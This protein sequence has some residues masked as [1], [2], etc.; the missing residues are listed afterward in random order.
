MKMKENGKMKKFGLS[1]V[2]GLAAAF[3]LGVSAYPAVAS[4]AEVSDGA[5]KVAVVGTSAGLEGVD[6]SAYKVAIAVNEDSTID[7][8]EKITVAFSEDGLTKFYRSIPQPTEKIS[9]VS[10]VCQ[11]NEAFT[12]EVVA[13]EG[14]TTIDCYGGVEKGNAWTYELNYTVAID[15]AALGD[16]LVFNIV[17]EEWTETLENVEAEITMP[18]SIVYYDAY[19]GEGEDKSNVDASLSDDGKTIIVSSNKN[20]AV[21]VADAITVKILL[22]ND[23]LIQDFDNTMA[24]AEKW[25]WPPLL[26]WILGILAA[27]LCVVLWIAV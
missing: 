25:I 15:A 16:E 20:E 21:A 5:D 14:V 19:S 23:A 24:E 2:T 13:S 1:L 10:A 27:L 6:V 4:A 8:S 11:G 9:E 7:V 17:G 12:Y 18:D 26:T 3:M 22:P